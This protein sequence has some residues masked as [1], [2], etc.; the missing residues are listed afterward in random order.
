MKKLF[1]PTTAVLATL[2]SILTAGST[3]AAGLDGATVKI[4]YLYPTIATVYAVLGTGT[5]TPGGYTVNSFGQHNYTVTDGTISLTNVAT[6][7]IT[8]DRSA[9]N[10]YSLTV[11]SGGENITGVT[12]DPATTQAGFGQER[13]FF[14]A[15]HVW[16]NM[17]GLTTEPGLDVKLDLHFSIL[18]VK[19]L[20]NT[21]QTAALAAGCTS[22]L[23]APNPTG[24]GPNVD[25]NWQLLSPY[26]SP[27]S[28]VK[29]PCNLTGFINAWVDTP[30]SAWLP[31]NVSKA[32]EWVT[33]FDGE[34]TPPAGWYV[35]RVDFPVPALLPSGAP[36]TGVTVNGQLASDNV[37]YGI[38]LESPANSGQCSIV[39]GQQF[40][41]N[42]VGAGGSNFSD[43]QQW[44]PF[45][46][47]NGTPLTAGANASLYFLILNQFDSGTSGPSPT[48]LRVEFFDTSILY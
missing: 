11:L 27:L 36:P 26:P 32:S 33:P 45:G 15:T 47:T 6:G 43:F 42:P 3:F 35:Y 44:W 24:G 38:Y 28:D 31:N 9:F 4:D 30:A 14:D 5:V 20:C 2:V 12:I 22:A 1:P 21:G 17:H 29:P 7:G 41:V 37:T 10:G 23:V 8:F 13:V 16:L 19:G 39:Y 25:G 34:G 46:F 40:P 48:G 18:S